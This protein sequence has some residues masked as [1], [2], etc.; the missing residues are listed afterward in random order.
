[1]CNVQSN[2]HLGEFSPKRKYGISRCTTSDL[3]IMYFCRRQHR[4]IRFRPCCHR[5]VAAAQ[6]LQTTAARIRLRVELKAPV[7]IVPQSSTSTNALVVDLGHISI[8][9]RFRIGAGD[10]RRGV[11]AVLEDM[12]VELTALKLAR[13]VGGGERRGG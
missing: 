2:N 6:S 13:W 7:I 9:N 3:K 8:S 12:S 1:M 10:T 11:P 5:R 4:W